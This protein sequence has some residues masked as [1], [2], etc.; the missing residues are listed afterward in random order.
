MSAIGNWASSE[1]VLRGLRV[2][3][4]Q[5]GAG[6]SAG[7]ASSGSVVYSNKQR[8]LVFG[9]RGM[10]ARYRHLM[11]DVRALMPHHKPES[12]VRPAHIAPAAAAAAA[13]RCSV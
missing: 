10:T 5:G 4:V 6:S 9:S 8:I 11:E 12:K 1:P 2:L 7:A 3:D 13:I